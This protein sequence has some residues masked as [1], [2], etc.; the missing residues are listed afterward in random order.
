MSSQ[1]VTPEGMRRGAVLVANGKI[2]SVVDVDAVPP[3]YRTIRCEGALL[4]GLVDSHIHIN[5]PGRT[6]WEG[7]ATATRAAA[8]ASAVP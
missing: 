8:A 4:P 1:I 2:L 3:G 7:F 6:E 5:E